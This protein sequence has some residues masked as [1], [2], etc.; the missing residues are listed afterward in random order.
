M[1]QYITFTVP[2]FPI[3][4][5][6][7][8]GMF[9]QGDRHISRTFTVFD[10][11]YVQKG[12]LFITENDVPYHVKE[13]EYVILS[14]GLPHYGH[15]ASS[16]KAHYEWLHFMIETFDWTDR[17]RDHW[18][19]LKQNQATFEKPARYEF[20]L[21]RKGRVK[22]RSIIEKQLSVMR[23]LSDDT[24]ELPLRKQLQ[25]EELLIQLQ[26]EA[27]HIPSAKEA[28]ASEVV[29]WIE[30]HFTDKL[31]MEQ[32]S[33]VLHYHPDYITRCMQTVYGLTPNQYANR[34]K[35]EKA[36]RLLT[37]TNEK[38]ATISEQIGID[39]PTYFSKLF[40]QTEGMTPIQYR[41]LARRTS[42]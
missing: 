40:K 31:Q 30:H 20:S 12:E 32:L 21:P 4:I 10:F 22:S 28:V 3:Y 15:R 35:I 27:F 11:L 16:E 9:R 18:F 1:S 8:E 24:S 29:R 14:P 37:S 2:P 36:K 23:A 41:N 6:S 25:F 19:D 33:E 39:D 34:L 7:G 17:A 26:K 38:M 5:A 42:R 13:G